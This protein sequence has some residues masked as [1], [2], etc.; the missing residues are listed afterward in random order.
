M[1][2]YVLILGL[3]NE[4][5]LLETI[6]TKLVN[7]NVNKSFTDQS[8]AETFSI[9]KLRYP[10]ENFAE[11]YKEFFTGATRAQMMTFSYNQ[12]QYCL[13]KDIRLSKRDEG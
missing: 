2:K 5:T 11:K 9:L 10:T 4:K 13:T 6:F 1:I 3:E 12:V 7:L 8:Y